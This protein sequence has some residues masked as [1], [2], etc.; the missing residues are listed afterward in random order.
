[1]SK[2]RYV[3][4]VLYFALILTGTEGIAQASS[5]LSPEF[6]AFSANEMTFKEAEAFC[7]KKG[8]RLPLIN[9]SDSWDGSSAH[10]ATID[11]FGK[12]FSASHQWPAGLPQRKEKNIHIWTGTRSSSD[13]EQVF[14]LWDRGG[15]S[16]VGYGTW[17]EKGKRSVVCVPK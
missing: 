15:S 7:K 13:S 8:G 10:G 11:G 12:L 4:A 9:S 5:K 1:M 2:G 6:V 14:T 3:F 17:V 16:G